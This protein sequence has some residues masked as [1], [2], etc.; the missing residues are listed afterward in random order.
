MVYHVGPYGEAPISQ[1]TEGVTKKCRQESL[2]W[3]PQERMDKQ[4][5]QA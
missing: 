4:D 2:L 3:I 5:K 1:E